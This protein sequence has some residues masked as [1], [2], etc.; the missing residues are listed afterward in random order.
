MIIEIDTHGLP[1]KDTHKLFML[2]AD[3]LREVENQKYSGCLV[4]IR[5]IKNLPIK[6]G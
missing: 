4:G 2:V 6:G 1:T 5:A 3:W